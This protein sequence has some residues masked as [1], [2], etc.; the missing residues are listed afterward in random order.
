[1]QCSSLRWRLGSLRASSRKTIDVDPRTCICTGSLRYVRPS[2]SMVGADTPRCSEV[3]HKDLLWSHFAPS[4]PISFSERYHEFV[5]DGTIGLYLAST[6]GRRKRDHSGSLHHGRPD[7]E[8]TEVMG[9]VVLEGNSPSGLQ[10]RATLIVPSASALRPKGR[11]S[12]E[13]LSQVRADL[14]AERH[15]PFCARARQD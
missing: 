4:R 11:K 1:M 13:F 8:R 3:S 12:A 9:K 14:S 10:C 15:S 5:H 2:G 6:I 7:R